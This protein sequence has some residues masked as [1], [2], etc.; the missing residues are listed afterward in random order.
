MVTGP[1]LLP[2]SKT[3]GSLFVRILHSK[4][5]NVKTCIVVVV[6]YIQT[7]EPQLTPLCEITLNL[8]TYLGPA[9]LKSCLILYTPGR[10]GL[11]SSND[12]TRLVEH[13]INHRS[14]AS[15]AEKSFSFAAPKL[16][17]SLPHLCALLIQ[18][19]FSRSI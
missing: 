13:K 15:A 12:T 9:Y 11:R 1:R 2:Q 3:I 18:F 5:W 4:T 8:P 17:N 7:R 16:W 14:L 10:V 19:I 6:T